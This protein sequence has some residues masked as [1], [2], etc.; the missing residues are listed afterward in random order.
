[1]LSVG[2][3]NQNSPP[4]DRS[5]QTKLTQKNSTQQQYNPSNR[6]ITR[7]FIESIISKLCGYSVKIRSLETYQLA[8]VHKSVYRK[9]LA[10]PSDVIKQYLDTTKQ[11]S[12]PYPAPHP[13]AMYRPDS[14]PF[15]FTDTYEAIEWAGDRWIDA[16][17]AQ[18]LIKRFPK[19][20]EGFYSNLKKHVVC[21]DGLSKLS[22]HLNFGEYALLSIDAEEFLT[23]QNPSLLEDI[24]E[25]FCYCVVEDLGIGVLQVMIK[26]LI[27]TVI[28]FRPVIINDS[29]YKE[30]FRRACREQ[31]WEDPEYVDLGDNGLVGSKREFNAGILSADHFKEAGLKNST[32]TTPDGKKILILSVGSGI[33][34]KKA[35]AAAAL[36]AYK[37]LEMAM[38][39]KI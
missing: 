31:G 2:I 7:E 37:T 20:N 6:P 4:L 3:Q 39:Y 14:K 26:N 11:N 25:A 18:Y 32:T 10:P 23:R 30:V 8:F 5:I 34:K 12:V 33:T 19:Q 36:H 22:A 21:K 38:K 28:D 9:N 15:V 29:N 27:E 13:V 35:Q 16:A 1:M 17:V 24:F